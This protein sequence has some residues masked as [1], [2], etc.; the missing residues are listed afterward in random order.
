MNL[1]SQFKIIVKASFVNEVIVA[2]TLFKILIL[3]KNPVYEKPQDDIKMERPREKATNL[4]EQDSQLTYLE[5]VDNN[6]EL[7]SSNVEWWCRRMGQYC[8]K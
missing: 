8:K 7:V 5:P 2:I 6:G 1:L 3:V 4:N